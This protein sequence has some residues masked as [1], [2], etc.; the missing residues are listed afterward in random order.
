MGVF[1]LPFN[2]KDRT[3]SKTF[4]MSSDD[5]GEATNLVVDNGSGLC[6]CG[7]AGDDATSRL[8]IHRWSTTT[9]RCYGWYG[10]ERL[11]CRRRSPVQ[12]RYPHL[13]IPSRARYH[14][15]LG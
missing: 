15:Q 1:T 11:L 9:S 5:E 12:T 3:N 6:K 14:H 4:K 10:P 13:E 7:F 2:R 8:P